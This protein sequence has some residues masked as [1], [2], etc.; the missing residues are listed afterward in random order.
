LK[1]QRCLDVD[2]DVIVTYVN[3]DVDLGVGVDGVG[4]VDF[5]AQS[6]TARRAEGPSKRSDQVHDAVAVKVTVAVNVNVNV[7]VSITVDVH[8]THM[9]DLAHRSHPSM[10]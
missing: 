4:D 10:H 9:S 6:L 8:E 7:N 3:V 5:V 1:R 2:V